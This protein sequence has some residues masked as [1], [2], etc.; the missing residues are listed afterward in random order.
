MP[1]WPR[2]YCSAAAFALLAAGLAA[3]PVHAKPT[4]NCRVAVPAEV[5]VALGTKTEFFLGLVPAKGFSV[6]AS[7]P[8]RIS[9]LP[10][11]ESELGLR[12][13][14]LRRK[15]AEDS[16]SPAPRFPVVVEG[17]SVGAFAIQVS[18]RFWLCKAS[19]CRSQTLKSVFPV[20]VEKP[21]SPSEILPDRE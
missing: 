9:L 6:S 19:L 16:A 7:G 21:D 5:R 14:E 2:K 20:I 10:S 17:S 8:L 15:H 4:A 3:T 11:S 12:R 13:S 1:N 18:A